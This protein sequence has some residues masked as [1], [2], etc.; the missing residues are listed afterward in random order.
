MG[1]LRPREGWEL[2]QDVMGTPKLKA[3]YPDIPYLLAQLVS[4]L[5]DYRRELARWPD[6]PSLSLQLPA[7]G[8]PANRYLEKQVE[9]GKHAGPIAFHL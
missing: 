6:H 1:K 8:S 9:E 4:K 7:V 2:T 5:S 3:P